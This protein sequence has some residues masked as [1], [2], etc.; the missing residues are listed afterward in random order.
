ML[1]LVPADLTTKLRLFSLVIAVTLLLACLRALLG[2][3][4]VTPI[5][6]RVGSGAAHAD[7][8]LA[9]AL[10]SQ[11]SF[12]PRRVLLAVFRRHGQI[13]DH[14][15]ARHPKSGGAG[16]ITHHNFFFLS[17][18]YRLIHRSKTQ[19]LFS[20]AFGDVYAILH[21]LLRT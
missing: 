13:P 18:D 15:L 5:G 12:G 19:L 10:R 11:L 4:N 1:Q 8:R 14:H 17:G 21:L 16:G 3:S 9:A 2:R 7:A 6:S 20:G